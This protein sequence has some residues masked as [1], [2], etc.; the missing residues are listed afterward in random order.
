MRWIF[1]KY[2]VMRFDVNSTLKF[3]FFLEG[4][5]MFFPHKN[6]FLVDYKVIFALRDC[7]LKEELPPFSIHSIYLTFFHLFAKT[8]FVANTHF[9][10]KYPLPVFR[11]KLSDLNLNAMVWS[12]LAGSD[13][14]S[15]KEHS[16]NSQ[17]VNIFL[18]FLRFIW[19]ANILS[20]SFVI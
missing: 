19:F 7:A 8:C 12:Q 15:E 6:S 20:P 11:H 13:D 9:R 2:R 3:K 18:C 4:S 5:E 1:E 16:L 14:R 17:N 10:C